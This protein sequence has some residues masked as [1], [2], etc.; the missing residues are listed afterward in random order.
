MTAEPPDDARSAELLAADRAHVWHPYAPMPGR[1]APLLV[2]SAS[3]TRL[4]LADGRELVDGMSSWWAAAWGYRHPELDAALA[5]QAAS[6]SHVMFGGLTHEPAIELCRTLVEITPAGLDHVFLADSGSVS[7]EVAIKMCLQYWRSRGRPG[8][9]RLLTWRG[10]YH[11]DTFHPMSV[12]DPDGGMHSLW[13]GVLPEQVF[14]PE[15]PAG[16]DTPAD[17]TYVQLIHD[18]I[19]RHADELAAVIVEPVVQGAGGMRFHSPAYLRALR[20]ACDAHNVLLVFDEI[21]TGFGRSGAM[22]AADHA[23]VS[24]DV[25]CVGKALTGGYLSLAA[26]LSTSE[27]ADGISRG[28]LPVLAHG[29]TFMGNPLACAVANAAVRLA[30]A[31]ETALAVRRIEAGLRRGLDGLV[32]LSGVKDVRVCGAIGVVQ[33]SSDVDMVAATEAAVARGVWLRPFRDLIYAMPPF[34]STD[35]DVESI[36]AAIFAAVEA[37]TGRTS[38]FQEGN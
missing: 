37:S 27:V 16:F 10:G 23:G 12:C 17:P 19:A 15:P 5:S 24:P 3:G 2:S 32:D 35:E 18:A 9:R 8:K 29:P 13:T 36:C 28:A 7:V 14:I 6:M 11:G 20:E 26:A 4:H 33:L 31:P 30:R 22:F 38:G 25:M 34:I 1:M 21:A